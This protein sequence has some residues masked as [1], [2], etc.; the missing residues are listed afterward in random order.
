MQKDFDSINKLLTEKNLE[1]KKEV[2]ELTLK[3]SDILKQKIKKNFFKSET[4]LAMID[5]LED[6]ILEIE[7]ALEKTKKYKFKLE[8]E[9]KND[10]IVFQNDLGL[11]KVT[12]ESKLEEKN[13]NKM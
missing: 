13:I 3:Q 8:N 7:K 1:L 9:I 4:I 6:N 2:D 11:K 12:K 5:N 10:K